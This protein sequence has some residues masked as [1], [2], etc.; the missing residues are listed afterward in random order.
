MDTILSKLQKD[1]IS[2]LFIEKIIEP[3]VKSI[4]ENLASEYDIVDGCFKNYTGLCDSASSEF[5]KQMNEYF[6][7]NKDLSDELKCSVGSLHGEQKHSPV[8]KSSYWPLQHT[9][10]FVNFARM[11]VYVDITCQ[12]FK[13]IYDD[14]PDYYISKTKPKWFYPDKDNPAWRG[15]FGIGQWL[16]NHINI[17]HKVTDKGGKRRNVKEGLIEFFQYEIWGSISDK[18]YEKKHK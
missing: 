14:I 9:W 15:I 5:C 11:T 17:S 12:Q 10:C 7:K 3:R 18:I 16:N 8:I 6:N 1:V 4:R 2:K 13:S